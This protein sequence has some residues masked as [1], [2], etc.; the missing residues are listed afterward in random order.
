[1]SG[2]DLRNVHAVVVGCEHYQLDGWDLN[3]PAS[4][5]LAMS[6]WLVKDIQVPGPNVHLVAKPLENH[7]AFEREVAALNVKSHGAAVS[8]TIAEIFKTHLIDGIDDAGRAAPGLLLVF[9]SGHGAIRRLG[10]ATERILFCSDLSEARFEIVVLS[11]LSAWLA[12]QLPQFR[13]VFLIDACATDAAQINAEDKLSPIGFPRGALA[14]EPRQLSAFAAYQT[15]VARN[16]GASQS[17]LFTSRLMQVLAGFRPR[18]VEEFVG[19]EQVVRDTRELV[20]EASDNEQ[21]LVFRMEDWAGSESHERF[22]SSADTRTPIGED[23]AYLCDRNEQW[24]TIR[25]GAW[26][27]FA[28]KPKRPLLIIAHGGSDQAPEA[29]LNGLRLRIDEERIKW[30]ACESVHHSM[31]DI[32]LPAR[33]DADMLTDDLCVQVRE[34]VT[35]DPSVS[36]DAVAETIRKRQRAT[37]LFCPFTA[38]ALGSKPGQRLEPLYQ[39]LRTFPDVEGKGCLIFIVFVSYLER[40]EGGLLAGLSRLF[41]DPNETV[42]AYV[43]G[44]CG[45]ADDPRFTRQCVAPELGPVTRK[46]LEEWKATLQKRF[47]NAAVPKKV[48]LDKIVA[49]DPQPMEVVLER[50]WELI[51]ILNG[52]QCH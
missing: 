31:L 27:H 45:A 43:Q 17:G 50:L 9:W 15:Q 48:Q 4:D 14:G 10:N 33:H 29:F 13:L 5:A 51:G 16:L 38:E 19:L 18:S 21:Q 24:L 40:R 37:L 39:F 12:D 44:M 32:K 23:A 42:R 25:K 20:R 1:M 52:Q 7:A 3:G 35:Q 6:R 2:A 8:A 49:G 46:D 26:Q 11:H 36:L 30:R 47:R 41:G 34:A 22:G 28:T